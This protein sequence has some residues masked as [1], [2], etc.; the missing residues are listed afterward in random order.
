MSSAIL[1]FQVSPG[2]D[3]EFPLNADSVTLGR[4]PTNA[5]VIQNSWIS[6]KHAR[7]ARK[8]DGS[9]EVYDLDSQNG[10][11]VN[12]KRIVRCALRDGDKVAFGQVEA[13][14]VVPENDASREAKTASIPVGKNSEMQHTIRGGNRA[15]LDRSLET[16][17]DEQAALTAEVEKLQNIKGQL[18]AASEHEP[19]IESLQTELDSLHKE[20]V[21][22]TAARDEI[23][24]ESSRTERLLSGLTG[25][26]A[27]ASKEKAAL[28]EAIAAKA[29]AEEALKAI[30]AKVHASENLRDS[31]L[32]ELST[33]EKSQTALSNSVEEKKTENTTLTEQ[34]TELEKELMLLKANCEKQKAAHESSEVQLADLQKTITNAEASSIEAKQVQADLT[35]LHVQKTSLENEVASLK[36]TVNTFKEDSEKAVKLRAEVSALESSVASLAPKENELQEITAKL[37]ITERGLTS[38]ISQ[39]TDAEASYTQ[40]KEA[41]DAAQHELA[42]A[43]ANAKAAEQNK[44]EAEQSAVSLKERVAELEDQKETLESAQDL[45]WGTVHVLAKNLIRRID[46]LDDLLKAVRAGKKDQ[47]FVDQLVALREALLDI[48]REHSV[49]AFHFPEGTP[50]DLSTRK[51]ILILGGAEDSPSGKEIAATVRPGYF[52]SNGDL[53]SETLLRKAEVKIA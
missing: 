30:E 4:D 52:C 49:E 50:I 25:K 9:F 2:Q 15:E 21:E 7:F 34:K 5:I 26:V 43:Q 27:E 53:G 12:G 35:A 6:S 41:L 37:A 44:S 13:R 14:F 31:I 51:R 29:R 22:A 46:L 33:L 36:D 32:S 38:V 20:I 24:E 10:I 28:G 42:S 48:L 8:S 3:I 19:A 45:E 39:T 40:A 18:A 11:E 17:R 16:L 1:T 47:D 23:V